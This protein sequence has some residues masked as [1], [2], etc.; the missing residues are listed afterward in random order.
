MA[1][2]PDLGKSWSAH[3]QKKLLGEQAR[4][5]G[6]EADLTAIQAHMAA[7]G[8]EGVKGAEE[9]V[10]DLIGKY[11]DQMKTSAKQTLRE[12]FRVPS[13]EEIFPQGV[14]GPPRNYPGW[15]QINPRD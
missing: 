4:K 12:Q 14:P 1:Q 11:K 10:R 13:V 7:L 3:A 2:I 9:M 5:T 8:L 6:N 15:M